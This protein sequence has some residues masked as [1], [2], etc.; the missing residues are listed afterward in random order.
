MKYNNNLTAEYVRNI[1]DYNPE[2]GDFIW[3]I[4]KGS[5]AKKEMVA[6][7]IRDG[8]IIIGI[9]NK[10]YGAHRLAWLYMAGNWPKEYIDHINGIRGDNKWCNLRETSASQNLRNRPKAKNNKSGHK[11]VFWCK[12]TKK[13]KAILSLGSFNTKEEAAKVYNK[14]EK[15]IFGEYT[16]KMEN[17]NG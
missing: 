15:Y 12:N 11:G 9:N 3:K 17:K 8:Y 7:T 1:L 2:T 6:G 14:T 13:W 16:W 5:R 4:N 10:E